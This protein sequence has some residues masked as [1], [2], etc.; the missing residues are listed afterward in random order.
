MTCATTHIDCFIHGCKQQTFITSASSGGSGAGGASSG[1]S[2]GVMGTMR[3]GDLEALRQYKRK[4]LNVGY[5][6]HA[7]Y[8]NVCMYYLFADVDVDVHIAG[9]EEGQQGPQGALQRARQAAELHV[10]GGRQPGP[11]REHQHRRGEALPVAVPIGGYF[12]GLMLLTVAW[13][14]LAAP[15]FITHTQ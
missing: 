1:D 2:A 3:A 15:L 7:L 9:G 5:N 10:P 12:D 13:R 11:D 4:K 14:Y 8:H 6:K